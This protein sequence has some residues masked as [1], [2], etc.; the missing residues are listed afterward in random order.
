MHLMRDLFAIAK[1]LFRI[2]WFNKTF[3]AHKRWLYRACAFG[4]T[5]TNLKVFVAPC[6]KLAKYF[7]TGAH[8]QYMVW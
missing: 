1:F 5:G 4:T 2:A 7:Y 6:N 3:G 8:L